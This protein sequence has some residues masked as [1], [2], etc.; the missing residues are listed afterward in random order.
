MSDS[1]P[2]TLEGQAVEEILKEAR[3]SKE[4]AKDFGALAWQKRDVLPNKRFL[5]N[6]LVSTLRHGYRQDKKM[7]DGS[8]LKYKQHMSS[9]RRIGGRSRFQSHHDPIEETG[10]EPEIVDY[11]EFDAMKYA[12]QCTGLYIRDSHKKHAKMRE[13]FV[14]KSGNTSSDDS[15]ESFTEYDDASTARGDDK[16]RR[17]DKFS[18]KWTDTGSADEYNDE[19]NEPSDSKDAKRSSAVRHLESDPGSE[20]ESSLRSEYRKY[21]NSRKKK[22]DATQPGTSRDYDSDN[23]SDPSGTEQTKRM[24]P[25]IEKRKAENVSS[26]NNSGTE[27]TDNSRQKNVTKKERKTKKLPVKGKD[28]MEIISNRS[29]YADI[30]ELREKGEKVVDDDLPQSKFE[31]DRRKRTAIICSEKEIEN[32]KEKKP[33]PSR[34]SSEKESQRH[35]SPEGYIKKSQGRTA[36]L[37]E[38]RDDDEESSASHHHERNSRSDRV[39]HDQSEGDRPVRHS[40][41]EDER[42][43]RENHRYH[44]G[45]GNFHRSDRGFGRGRESRLPDHDK[46]Y[47]ERSNSNAR[48]RESNERESSSHRHSE[49]RNRRNRS[50]SP[51]KSDV[52]GFWRGKDK[53]EKDRKKTDQ[54]DFDESTDISELG[55]PYKTV[56]DECKEEDDLFNNEHR[57]EF[58]GDRVSGFRSRRPY[59][60]RPFNMRGFP[61]PRG[62]PFR[63]RPPFRGGGFPMMPMPV[64]PF[65]ATFMQEFLKE[66][67]FEEWLKKKAKKFHRRHS[68]SDSSSSRSRSSHRRSHRSKRKKRRH[69]S[70]SDRSSSRSRSRHRSRSRSRR[71]Y[72]SSSSR[73]RSSSRS[74]S[75]SYSRSR[76]RS[77][78]HKSR[79]HSSRSNSRSRSRR[80]SYTRS[81]SR[82]S[83]HS[84]HSKSYGDRSWSRSKEKSVE[85]KDVSSKSNKV[86]EQEAESTS[87]LA[88]E[89]VEEELLSSQALLK[90]KKSKKKEKHK[91]AK[92]K[93]QSS[94]NQFIVPGGDIVVKKR[95]KKSRRPK[96][97]KTFVEASST[98][99]ATEVMDFDVDDG[100]IID[101]EAENVV[102]NNENF[103]NVSSDNGAAWSSEEEGE[104]F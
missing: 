99:D 71:R 64:D 38:D 62:R 1:D 66:S 81:R 67:G 104:V 54:L 21:E 76:S 9:R 59:R 23:E 15:E 52:D 27:S 6:T 80:K 10:Q 24:G 70:Y 18:S 20:E 30:E 28:L 49:E 101:S 46:G 26:G 2:V 50:E 31:K 92:N 17:P 82:H 29:M 84:K 22:K 55:I 45:R 11:G 51:R 73:H 41:F 65:Y 44:R 98:F 79:S 94:Q 69:S 3:R 57:N 85:S 61:F 83:S 68:D 33:K 16:T 86:S 74:R 72:S 88:L 56:G 32:E 4:L 58:S 87:A 102:I 77:R 97:K 35:K 8:Y 40:R 90:H 36:M 100:E 53:L 47:Q 96:F 63:G 95:K 7:K 93:L 14:E 48:R 60:G 19:P 25:E 34:T 12:E 91:T 42:G 78:K 39:R 43:R 13:K 75:R 5:N 103:E 89:I 37:Y